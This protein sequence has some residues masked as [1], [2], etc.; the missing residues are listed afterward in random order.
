MMP[1][2][3]EVRCLVESLSLQHQLVGG[4]YEMVGAQLLS[5]RYQTKGPPAGWE[6]VQSLLPAKLSAINAKGKF[7]W[8]DLTKFY[9]FNTL[10]LSGDWTV[11][12]NDDDADP[13]YARVA[14]LFRQC[15]SPQQ[16]TVR[17]V[18][19]DMIGY[20]TLKLVLSKDELDKKL[21]QLGRD[22]LGHDRPTFEDFI[23]VLGKEKKSKPLAKLLMEQ[24]RFCGV[25][26]YILSEVLYR[27]RVSP[28]SSCGALLEDVS[29]CRDVYNTIADVITSSYLSQASAQSVQRTQ[30]HPFTFMVYRQSV[31]RQTGDSIVKERGPHGR[32]V[33]W[34]P[35]L[36]TR[37]HDI[38]DSVT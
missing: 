21:N 13:P 19:S 23:T 12:G 36:Q 18:F 5:G 25:G 7:I 8:F 3:P 30:S 28:F 27:A 17:L 29:A 20:G 6:H 15:D 33:F 14:L 31:C 35:R 1:E 16:H 32:S 26:N 11:V 38:N 4:K 10:G 24:K 22:W 34:V 37:C 2:G 9:L